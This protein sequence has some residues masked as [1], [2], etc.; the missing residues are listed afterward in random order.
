MKNIFI[1]FSLFLFSFCVAQQE[2]SSKVVDSLFREDQFYA[3]ISYN[4]VQNRPVGFQQ[5]SFSSGVTLGFLRDFPISKN[6]KWAIAPGFGYNYNNI[7]QFINS[8]DLPSNVSIIAPEDVRTK[9]VTHLVDFPIEFRWRNAIPD[10]HKF[11]RI[12]LGFKASYVLS[13]KLNVESNSSGNEQSNI[14]DEMN[15][16]QYG[17]YLSFGYNTWNPY[18]YYGLNPLFNEGSKLTNLNFGFIFYI[19]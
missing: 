3:S 4:L 9:I 18:V 2:T 16:W 10:D 6:R 12:N 19:L 5:Y 8:Q 17:A 1:F 14:I 15:Q 13:A 7:K 11:W